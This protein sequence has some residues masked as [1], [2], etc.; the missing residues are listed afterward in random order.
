MKTLLVE[1][2][3]LAPFHEQMGN[4]LLVKKDKSRRP[5]RVRPG[6]AD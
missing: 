6:A 4:L 5:A 1:R 3:D 2:P